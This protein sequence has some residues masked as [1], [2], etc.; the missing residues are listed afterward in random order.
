MAMY[1][2]IYQEDATQSAATGALS[3]ALAGAPAGPAGIAAG[4]IIGAG[5]GFFGS[6][7]RNKAARRAEQARRRRVRDASRREM[8]ARLQAES[9]TAAAPRQTGGS[10][11]SSSPQTPMAQM[12][13][14]IIGSNISNMPT[15]A[16]TF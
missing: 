6:S 16:G 8:E 4:A 10:Q 11:S 5:L 1:G 9:L 2:D 7:S 12:N 13:T 15:S 14:G 3:G